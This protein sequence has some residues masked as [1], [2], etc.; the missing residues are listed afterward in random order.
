M[1]HWHELRFVLLFFAGGQFGESVFF[2]P[3]LYMVMTT[4]VSPSRQRLDLWVLL[5]ILSVRL[6]V[7]DPLGPVF[8]VPHKQLVISGSSQCGLWHMIPHG[9]KA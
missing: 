6:L 5:L 4:S 3:S 2:M 1:L 8:L 9:D 7:S